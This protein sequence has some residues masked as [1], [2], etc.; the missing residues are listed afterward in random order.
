M[1]DFNEVAQPIICDAYEEPAQHREIER[2]T[3]AQRVQGRR[4]ACYY[5][6][7]PGRSTGTSEADDIGTRV[8]LDL[9]NRLRPLVKSWTRDAL[10]GRP[11]ATG[12]TLE[13]LAYWHREGRERRL[14]FCQREAVETVMFLVEARADLLQ[15][16]T[17]PQDEPGQFVRYACKMATGSGKT[18]VMAG[19][20]A[21]SILNKIAS[22]AD[23]RFSDAVLV[24]CPNVTIRDRLQELDPNRGET[25]LYRTRDLLPPHLMSDL[26]KGH[27]L[28][29]NWHVLAP[30]DLGQVGGVGA[31]VV[32]RGL[33]SDSAL[34]ARILG[35]EV[36]GKR[37]ILVLNDE[38]HH[39]YRI[40]PGETDAAGD[41]AG[42]APEADP[43]EATVWIEGLDKIHRARSINLC[44]DLSATPFYLNR[45]GHDPGRAF[46]WVISDFG[47]IDAIESGLVKIPQIPVQDTTGDV[48]PAYF[49]IWKWIVEKKLSAGERGGRRGELNADAVLRWAQQPIAQLAGQWFEEFRRWEREAAEGTRPPVPPVFIVVCRDTR[50]ARAVHEWLTGQAR[51]APPPVEEFRNPPGREHTVRIDSRVVE[52]MARDVARTDQSR[53]LRFVLDTIGRTAWPGGG[54]PEEYRELVDRLNRKAEEEDGPRIDAATPRGRDVRCI[55]SVAMLTEGWDATTV[56]HIV[57]L[58]PFESQ[59]LCEQVVG[60]GLRRSQYHDLTVEEVAKVYGV[61][62]ELIPLKAAPGR[63]TPPPDVRHVHA[64]SPERDHLEITFPRVEGYA[65]RIDAAVR[66]AWDRVPSL[67]LDPLA[68]PDETRV[69]GLSADRGGRLSLYGPGA[70]DEVTLGQWR[71]SHRQQELEFEMARD[72]TLR[73]REAGQVPLHALFPQVLAIVRRYV[74][75]RVTPLG[76][77]DRK[78]VF[79]D[80]YY[81]EAV[82]ALTA[83]ILPAD[84][85][86]RE[87]PRYE[88]RRAPGRTRDVDFW[89]SRPVQEAV[90]CHL[91]LVVLDTAK[92]EQSAAYYLDT[93]D[94]V[95][96][97]VKNANMGFAIPYLH[98][99]QH[100]EYLPDFL[101]RLGK[102]GREVGTLIL[103]T[104][105]FDPLAHVKVAAA[106]RWAAAVNAEGSCGRWAYRIAISPSIVPAALQ[107]AVRELAE[108][109]RP[110]WQAALSRFAAEIRAAYGSRLHSIV[111]YG[112]RARG[113]AQHDSDVDVL[114]VFHSG[115]D[116]RRERERVAATACQVSSD[117]DCLISAFPVSLREFRGDERPLIASARREGRVVPDQVAP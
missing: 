65:H 50:L 41:N 77:R 104:K 60:R 88:A 25:S 85:N 59:L 16:I 74:R 108:L 84:G 38:A 67:T 17:V 70:L 13:L 117:S 66:V 34:V 42:G 81:T 64:L 51:G 114:V 30:Q 12:M 54:P 103:E 113:D 105:G 92:W 100:R 94:H 43:R 4:E 44:L 1:A 52:D 115:E 31:R 37:N 33:E 73:L 89:T 69:K 11:V 28:I 36:G 93:S 6:R 32:Q 29:R 63:P 97:F 5:Y 14:F 112:S 39:A 95:V 99:G 18:T 72:L 76:H 101:V 22:R 48:T 79:L 19:L 49:N 107:S 106:Q 116:A 9:V 90:R 86:A 53:R 8:P 40:R 102:D 83:A 45:A 47:L 35:R 82:E 71:E 20:I 3:P 80:P 21:W 110:D 46:P 111:L 27:V 15:G 87:V 109:P 91:N 23:R 2:G 96:A 68:A 78:D 57:G 55:V 61:P 10:N 7:P 56:T 24:I 62:F 26:R 75:D 98:H 58:R